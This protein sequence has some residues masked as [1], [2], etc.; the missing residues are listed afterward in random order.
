MV[1]SIGMMDATYFVGR[2]EILAWI[3][4]TLHLNL[5]KVEE[6]PNSSEFLTIH[7]PEYS[8]ME[9]LLS[10]SDSAGQRKSRK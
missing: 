10:H 4:S 8:V 6:F 9:I 3:N 1:T 7:Y 5:S 2:T